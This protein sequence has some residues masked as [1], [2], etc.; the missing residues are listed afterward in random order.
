MFFRGFIVQTLHEQ[1][2]GLQA[3]ICPFTKEGSITAFNTKSVTTIIINARSEMKLH[4]A[5][6]CRLRIIKKYNV[7]KNNFL[8]SGKCLSVV[9]FY[10]IFRTK[11]KSHFSNKKKKH[12][13]RR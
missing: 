9:I 1:V 3:N 11:E 13:L 8:S 5:G 2:S 10:G 7:T 4:L 12:I 6:D